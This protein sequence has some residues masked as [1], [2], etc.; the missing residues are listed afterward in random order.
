MSNFYQ[1]PN[2]TSTENTYI[3]NS[4]NF[5]EKRSMIRSTF[6]ANKSGAL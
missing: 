5:S 4:D 1:L 3:L 2:M 6:A